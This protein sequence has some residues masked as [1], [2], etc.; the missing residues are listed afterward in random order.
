MPGQCSGVPRIVP[1]G[2][3]RIFSFCLRPVCVGGGQIAVVSMRYASVDS[4]HA[5]SCGN[6][7]I[8]YLSASC[9][10]QGWPDRC[11]FNEISVGRSSTVAPCGSCRIFLLSASVCVGGAKNAAASTR[12]ASVDPRHVASCGS[13]DIL[14]VCAGSVS[15]TASAPQS[16]RTP[17]RCGIHDFKQQIDH[18]TIGAVCRRGRQI[19]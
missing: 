13:C 16:D 15:G 14:P 2:N 7:T 5:A 3:C 11:S 9:L 12:F 19:R 4:R 17:V 18:T 6:C 10:H 1:C 8:F